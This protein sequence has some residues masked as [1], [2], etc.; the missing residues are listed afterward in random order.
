[1]SILA[2]YKRPGG[3]RQLVQ[4]IE[5]SQPVKQMQL[6]QAIEDEDPHWA[7]LIR[8]KK[9]TPEMVFEWDESYLLVIFEHMKTRHCATVLFVLGEGSLLKFQKAFTPE[10]LREMHRLVKSIAQPSV[11]ELRVA[12][13]HMLETVRHLDEEKKIALSL[14]DPKLDT[15]EAA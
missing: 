15:S 7:Q 8:E 1:M 12:Y 9:I 2:R 5:T 11:V 4:L 13:N 6:L 3:F 14:I 10:R